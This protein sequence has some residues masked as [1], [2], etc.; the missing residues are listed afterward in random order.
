LCWILLRI[1]LSDPQRLEFLWEQSDCEVKQR[2]R[3]SRHSHLLW[4][5]SCVKFLRF[6]GGHHSC[7]VRHR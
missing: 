4:R 1:V 3:G 6:R 2:R 5:I 7:R